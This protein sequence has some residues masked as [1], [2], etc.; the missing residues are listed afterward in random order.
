[1]FVLMLFHVYSTYTGYTII[2]VIVETPPGEFPG[3]AW[4]LTDETHPLGL[5]CRSGQHVEAP[6]DSLAQAA[7]RISDLIRL[8]PVLGPPRVSCIVGIVWI[9]QRDHAR[10]G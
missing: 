8:I 9:I 6:F 1:M 2:C 5:E 3:A 4:C 7:V 10:H